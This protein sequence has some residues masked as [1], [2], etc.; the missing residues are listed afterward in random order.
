M[1]IFFRFW[2]AYLFRLIFGIPN[3]GFTALLCFILVL[4]ILKI[5]N[6]IIH[7]IDW[8]FFYKKKKKFEKYI[9]DISFQNLDWV[10]E[11]ILIDLDGGGL[12][13]NSFFVSSLKIIP[14][15]S[16]TS[17]ISSSTSFFSSFSSSSV[18]AEIFNYSWSWFN[19][20]TLLFFKKIYIFSVKLII[21]PSNTT[22]K[23]SSLSL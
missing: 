9:T 2:L 22:L 13:T 7:E 5:E 1:K 15:S 16:E 4:F 18:P 12:E 14:S 11:T 8:Y 17:V 20:F 10:M 23:E 6:K 3:Q 19:L 21:I